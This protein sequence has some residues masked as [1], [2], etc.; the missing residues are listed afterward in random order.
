MRKCVMSYANN[1]G[2]DQP[3]HQCSLIC[4]FVGRCLNSIM[5]LDSIVE[6][7]RLLLAS[8]A[9]QAG[10]CLAWSETPEDMFC[11]VVAHIYLKLKL[12]TECLCQFKGTDITF[13][14]KKLF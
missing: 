12:V 11:R 3:V 1:K 2:A 13:Q 14:G 6:I 4:A 9:G 7:S 8:V 5:S 10:L